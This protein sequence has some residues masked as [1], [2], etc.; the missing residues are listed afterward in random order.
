MPGTLTVEVLAGTTLLKQT[1][2]GAYRLY[3]NMEYYSGP[4][5]TLTQSAL[6]TVVIVNCANVWTPVANLT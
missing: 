1:Y 5:P 3:I 4:G 6:F 2:V